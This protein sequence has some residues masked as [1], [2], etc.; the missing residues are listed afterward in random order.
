MANN[1]IKNIKEF[2][3][4]ITANDKV[5]LLF[6]K[7]DGSSRFMRATLNFNKIPE[8]KKPDKVDKKKLE[9]NMKKGIVH[10]YD[11]DKEGWRSVN[12]NTTYWVED[13]KENG[14]RYRI[15]K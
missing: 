13:G 1:L 10:V 11:L 7:K 8:S 15:K 4:F 2:Y 14:V 5:N 9:E 12:F 3:S 6:R